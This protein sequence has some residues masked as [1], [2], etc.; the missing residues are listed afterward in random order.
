MELTT[1]CYGVVAMELATLCCDVVVMELIATMAEGVL[2][3]NYNVLKQFLFY[4]LLHVAL[5]ERK[6]VAL[7]ERVCE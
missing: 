1:L 6:N 5:H 3:L 7:R 4:F 2:M